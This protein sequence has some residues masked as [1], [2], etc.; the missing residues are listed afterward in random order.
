MLFGKELDKLERNGFI[1]LPEYLT[2]SDREILSEDVVKFREEYHTDKNIRNR[3]SYPSDVTGS[4]V[5]NAYM[6]TTERQ[7]L[8]SIR[9]SMFNAP[10]LTSI[11]EDFQMMLAQVNR[12]SS[13]E[14]LPTRCMLNMQTYEEK[15]KPVPTHFDGEYFE[16][17]GD[18]CRL[19]RGLIPQ[20]VA[21]YTLYNETSGGTTIH[22]IAKGIEEDIESTPGDMLIL[23]NTRFLHSVKELDG[24][25]GVVGLRNFDY[26]PFYYNQESGEKI[27]HECFAGLREQVT[28][29]KARELHEDFI[30]QWK[31]RCDTQGVDE[32]KF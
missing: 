32:A 3:V 13:D 10:L 31:H 2:K 25:R 28:T 14:V 5:S 30:K 6:V 16:T 18:S 9:L 8:P 27:F 17:R 20:Y 22:N 29:V 19:I 15:S 26:N 7:F 1:V 21:V 23:D 4:R 11:V 12:V 24:R